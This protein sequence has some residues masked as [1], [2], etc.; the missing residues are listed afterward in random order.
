MGP[1]KVASS[2]ENE[3]SWKDTSLILDAGRNLYNYRVDLLDLEAKKLFFS[4]ESKSKVPRQ[5]DANALNEEEEPEIEERSPSSTLDTYENITLDDIPH[6]YI[7]AHFYTITRNFDE[8]GYKGLLMNSLN[9]NGDLVYQLDGDIGK[10][11]TK[12]QEELF[13]K[14]KLNRSIVRMARGLLD[15]QV[16]PQLSEFRER[17]KEVC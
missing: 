10:K 14:G 12:I 13:D 5:K 8:G 9:M 1:P 15:N 17:F 11:N 3:D 2:D 16:A 7:D 4:K 6:T